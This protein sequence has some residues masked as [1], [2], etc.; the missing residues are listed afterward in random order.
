MDA[1]VH[2]RAVFTAVK[3]SFARVKMERT[4]TK[5]WFYL[6]AQA[7]QRVVFTAVKRSFA[8]V[9]KE[10][11]EFL[12]VLSGAD[13]R[14]VFMAVKRSFAIVK[15]ERTHGDICDDWNDGSRQNGLCGR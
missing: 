2:Q 9:K 1:P 10:R 12:G 7:H 13:Q 11:T 15:K 6:D 3:R 5:A 8:I 4:K 14:A